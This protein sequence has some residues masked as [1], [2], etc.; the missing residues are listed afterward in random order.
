MRDWLKALPL[1]LGLPIVIGAAS[2][3]PEDAASNIAAWLHWM[4]V[5]HVPSWL[6]SPG[7]DNRIIEGAL[8]IGA[9]YAFLIWGCPQLNAWARLDA[10]KSTLATPRRS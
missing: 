5:E 2:V 9:I 4:G 1:G 7:I 8:G 3:K 6:S 10:I